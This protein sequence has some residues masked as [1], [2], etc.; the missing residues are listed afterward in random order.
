MQYRRLGKYGV[1]VSEISLGAF[2]TYGNSST[3]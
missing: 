1:Q 2:L 3:R